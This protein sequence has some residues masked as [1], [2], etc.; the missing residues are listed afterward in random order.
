MA[1][2]LP[3]QLNA[4]WLSESQELMGT[5]VIVELWSDDDALGKKATRE[6]MAEIERL[7][8][9]MNP[10]NPASE[11]ARINREAGRETVVTTPE[12]IEVVQRALL[13]SQLSEGAF[14]ISFASAGQHYDYKTG[15]V[16]DAN[17]LEQDRDNIDYQAVNLNVVSRSIAFTRP[18]LQIDLGG[19]AK[20]YAVDRGIQILRKHNITSAVITAGG[21]SRIL[22]DL[23]DRPRTIGIRHPRK[24][25]E[26]IVLIPLADTAISTSGDYERFFLRDGV[27]YHHILDPDTGRSVEGVQSASVMTDLA[28]DSDALSTTVFVLGVERGLALVNGLPG[29]DAIIIDGDGKLH[30]SDELLL[31]TTP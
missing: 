3:L 17:L 29:V 22:G 12:I 15:V 6:V 26:F 2:L 10:W 27:R 30:Y 5:Q 25:D 16:P 8:L 23:G 28:I 13:Y 18:G 4:A 11:L 24:N 14:D 1:L 19:I 31:N 9:M 20:G 7:D 21:D